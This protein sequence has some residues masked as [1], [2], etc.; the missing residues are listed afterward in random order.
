MSADPSP[1]RPSRTLAACLIAVL[2][3]IWGSTWI[4]IRGGLKDLPPYTSAAARFAVAGL[5]MTVVAS[6]GA[7]REGGAPPRPKLWIALGVCN[8]ALSYGIVYRTETLLPSGLVALLWGVFPMLMAVSGH[9][10]LEKERLGARQWIGM[11]LG[12]AGLAVL[13]A[14]DLRELGPG[15]LP[16]AL[17][18]FASPVV[19]AVGNT[20]VKREGAGTSSLALNRNGMLLGAALLGVAALAI[21]RDLQVRVTPAAV[22]SVLYLAIPG[23]VVTFGLY[24]WLLRFVDAHKLSLIAYV[25]PGIALALGSLLGD[26]PFTATLA[27]GAA[28]ILAGVVLVV[29]GRH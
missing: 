16:A 8:F 11:V 10:F 2:C 26:E 14:T 15:A 28:L 1:R 23:T 25:T 13:F 9:W 22:A 17:V 4:V 6:F 27:A 18:L 24:F 12:F 20:I 5:V 7:R 3:A 29:S 19:S 21:E